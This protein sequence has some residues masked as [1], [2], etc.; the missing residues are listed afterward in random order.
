MGTR[1]TNQKTNAIENAVYNQTKQ[2]HCF[3]AETRA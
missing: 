3:L 1:Y 2:P